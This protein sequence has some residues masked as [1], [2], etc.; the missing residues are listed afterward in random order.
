MTLKTIFLKVCSGR[1]SLTSKWTFKIHILIIWISK[2]FVVEHSKDPEDFRLYHY[3]LQVF[4]SE[5]WKCLKLLMHL[6]NVSKH[7]W[8]LIKL[9]LVVFC[10]CVPYNDDIQPVI[11]SDT[12]LGNLSSGLYPKAHKYTLIYR[13]HSTDVWLYIFFKFGIEVKVE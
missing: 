13:H 1:W 3:D 9:M 10:H 4:L 11:F 12:M 8:G 5:M 7:R 6:N 2:C